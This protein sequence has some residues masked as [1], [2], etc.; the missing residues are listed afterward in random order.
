MHACGHDVHMTCLVGTARWLA[1]HRDRWSGTVVLVGQPAEEAIGGAKAMLDDGLYTRFP[2][3]DSALALHVTHDLAT[4]T[5]GYTSGPGAGRLDGGRRDDP[6]QGRPRRAPR[7]RRSTRSSW[8]RWSSSTSRRSSAARSTRSSP[9]VVT[10]GSIHGGTKHNIIPNEVKLQLTLRAY[11]DDVRDQLIDGIKRR[12]D[13][14]GPGPPRPRARRSRSARATP[15]TVN[16]PEPGRPGRPG[17]CS[18]R[19]ARTNVKEVEPVMGAEDFGL[20]G[21][22][23]V[24]TFMFR[25]GTIPPERLAEAKAKGETLPSLHSASYHPDAVR[26]ASGPASGDDRGRRRAAAAP[27]VGERPTEEIDADADL[28]P[29][30]R[31][32]R[33]CSARR[34]SIDRGL[35]R[36]Q[37]PDDDRDGPGRRPAP[38]A[39]QDAQDARDRAARASRWASASTSARRSPRPRWS[40]R[41]AGP[42]SCSPTRSSGRTSAGSPSLVRHYPAT[43]FRALVDDPDAARALSEGMSGLGRPLPVL[44]DLEVGMGRTGIAPGDEAVGALRAGRPPAEPR[45]RRP[46][47]PTTARSTTSTPP[48]APRTAR[49]GIEQTLAAPRPAP[50]PG[51]ARAPA[52]PGRDADLPDPRR[53]RRAGRRVLARDL[54]RST[55]SATRPA[56]PTSRSP[57]PRPC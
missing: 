36:A 7:T 35:V 40:P 23:G 27:A 2:K 44:V 51:A 11:R 1:E 34:W 4:G 47:A 13:G 21:Q 54:R 6:R 42:T 26:R 41:R 3:P 22:G 48:P 32:R 45:P 10:V 33:R 30:R 28:V 53:A 25:L 49:T 31:H 39:R 20:F 14:P 18:R 56:T 15:P 50:G 5:V 12:V 29:G 38:A 24:P 19:S 9:C 43:V 55:T 37:P 52:G 46:A 57:P 17:A 8:P 16:T